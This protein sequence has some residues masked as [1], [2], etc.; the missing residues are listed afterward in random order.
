MRDPTRGHA[1]AAALE[2][3]E[4][5]YILRAFEDCDWNTAATAAALQLPLSTL[6]YRM[7]KLDVL[8]HAKHVRRGTSALPRVASRADSLLT[9]IVTAWDTEDYEALHRSLI[10]ARAYVPSPADA[11]PEDVTAPVVPH[12]SSSSESPC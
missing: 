1:L 5:Q 8:H 11:V 7:Q 9:A 3:F 4:R 2:A 6:K 12:A 10:Q